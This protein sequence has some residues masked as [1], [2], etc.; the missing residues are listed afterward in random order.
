MFCCSHAHTRNRRLPEDAEESDISA[1]V[2]RWKHGGASDFA[3]EE[4]AACVCVCDGGG[5]LGFGGG[6]QTLTL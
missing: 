1:S 4:G 6:A 5:V 2:L 3:S